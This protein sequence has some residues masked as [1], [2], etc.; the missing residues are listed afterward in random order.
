MKK[1]VFGLLAIFTL[2]MSFIFVNPKIENANATTAHNYSLTTDFA[3]I[4]GTGT[5]SGFTEENY[6]HF[7]VAG[8]G[9]IYYA[10]NI[11]S[12]S[13]SDH[14]AIPGPWG[15]SVPVRSP[16]YIGYEI[17]APQDTFSSV[18]FA[19]TALLHNFGDNIYHPT[20]Y[21]DI[22]YG[23]TAIEAY[24][25][26]TPAIRYQM[27]DSSLPGYISPSNSFKNFPSVDLTSY[28]SGLSTF[29]ILIRINSATTC[30]NNNKS[31][32]MS[33]DN[34]ILQYIGTKIKYVSISYS[35]PTYYDVDYDIDGL[36]FSS[37]P[38]YLLPGGTQSITVT[39]TVSGTY[40]AYIKQN[41]VY[42]HVG[43]NC[44][45]YTFTLGGNG[46]TSDIT[47]EAKS[48]SIYVFDTDRYYSVD[49]TSYAQYDHSW[50]CDI[51]ASSNLLVDNTSGTAT[52]RG[53]MLDSSYTQG[54]VKYGIN[55]SEGYESN[56][57]HVSG[58]A[59]VSGSSSTAKIVFSFT[60]DA[61][62]RYP[63]LTLSTSDFS[64]GG[65]FS[66][67]SKKFS[68]AAGFGIWIDFYADDG[69]TVVLND[70]I[71]ESSYDATS[72]T[73]TK[74]SI[75]YIQGDEDLEVPMELHGE[76]IRDIRIGNQY[77]AT[78]EYSV[79]DDVLYIN[80]DILNTFEV[81]MYESLIMTNCA[82]FPISIGISD[83]VTYPVKNNN[84][85]T[86]IIG[87]GN[88]DSHNLTT[89][90]VDNLA[91]ITGGVVSCN[92]NS[93][94]GLIPG[95]WSEKTTIT[96]PVVLQY[97]YYKSTPI[98]KLFNFTSFNINIIGYL[99]NMSDNTLH[100]N[101]YIS[102][103]VG[104]G[105]TSSYGDGTLVA[106]YSMTNDGASTTHQ[107]TSSDSWQDFGTIDLT[108]YII[109]ESTF[110]V[111]V[112]INHATTCDS[113]HT[114]EY[115]DNGQF[116]INYIGTR[117]ASITANYVL[118]E[119]EVNI[120]IDNY[121]HPE[122]AIDYYDDTGLCRGENGYYAQAK[123]AFLSMSSDGQYNFMNDITWLNMRL[124]YEAWARSNNDSTPYVRKA[125][126]SANTNNNYTNITT[127]SL[128]NDYSITI[129]VIC[130]GIILLLSS[131]L[132]IFI[133]IRKKKKR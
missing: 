102:V 108:S 75:T 67:Y 120:F 128:N 119:D 5:E 22:L 79:V 131:T 8:Q 113:N 68:P 35:T 98:D 29:Y 96:S 13:S 125:V 63:F 115:M 87:S 94:Y 112:V 20:N 126:T 104:D 26:S 21:I 11:S 52:N 7:V 53:L 74:N 23:S 83:G 85:F 42:E 59:K 124:R 111:F 38:S 31:T 4:S 84:V 43:P 49:Y 117:I 41:G 33:G 100:A 60:P 116:K 130:S 65:S 107:I 34:I 32:Y 88:G 28:A 78:S 45:S 110:K 39:P 57:V 69:D 73:L 62:S 132:T 101:N 90:D 86:G 95:N 17:T 106:K 1:R 123:E 2:L 25:C 89:S 97:V 109:N 121:M 30:D 9:N 44:T 127:A 6:P 14:G 51:Y 48:T 114:A 77:I 12:N 103:Y 50:A 19:M 64:S 70:L 71:F 55:D 118:T 91:S 72:A 56:I 37:Q 40:I 122:I 133:I 47:I 61:Q 99:N 82:S 105:D 54:N 80:H 58:H 129:I 66:A 27:Y 16:S 46:A 24:T 10:E 76:G 92:A 3:S 81:G 15:A 36:A 18:T 93:D